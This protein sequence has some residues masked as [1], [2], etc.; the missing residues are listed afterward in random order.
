MD[1]GERQPRVA[2]RRVLGGVI[3]VVGLLGVASV[4]SRSGSGGAHVIKASAARA[5]STETV[6]PTTAPTEP[7]APIPTTAPPATTPRVTVAPSA[8]VAVTPTTSAGSEIAGLVRHAGAPVQ[9]A[10]I[11]LSADGVALRTATTDAAG[12]Y[13]FEGVRPGAYDISIY[14]ESAAAPC[15]PG[16]PCIGSAV[17][18][19]QQPLVVA[20]AHRYEVDWE[21]PYAP[22]PGPTTTTTT[23][24]ATTS[25]TGV[26]PY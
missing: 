20:A 18:M 13:A 7:V 21:Y 19:Q 1:V 6:A 22:D 4:V 23:R 2:A 16:Q 26:R 12:H 11:T 5:A 15:Q 24:F 9:G 25:T 10:G 14:A 3:V 8:S 17:S